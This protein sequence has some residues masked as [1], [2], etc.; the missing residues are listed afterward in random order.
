MAANYWFSLLISG[1]VFLAGWA[2]PAPVSA[3]STLK[4]SGTGSALGTMKQLAEAFQKSHPGVRVQ[5]LPSLG[6]TGGIK[7]ALAGGIDLALS[8]R[9]LTKEEQQQGAKQEEY[10]RSPFVFIT[11]SRVN[12]QNVTIR[13]LEE[14]YSN[15]AARW[16]D[17]S[18]IRLILRPEKDID[19]TIIR[20]LSQGME[21]AVKNALA[22]PGMIMAITDQESGDVVAKTAGSLGGATLAEIISENRAVNILSFNGVHASVK[23]I[24]N[25]SYPLAKSFYLVTTSRATSEVRQ[26]TEFIRSTTA[27]RILTKNGN[28]PVTVK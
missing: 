7:S 11:N 24:A 2:L 9:P 19:T 15:P 17:G 18:R 23:T 8:S 20:N 14:F 1:V 25:K 4:I 26:F 22:R 21:Q 10:A 5:I 3:E 16:A 13:E 27:A 6:S 28:L 12:K